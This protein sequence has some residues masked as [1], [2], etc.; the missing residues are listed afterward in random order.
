M[1]YALAPSLYS[2][3]ETL[4]DV[5][6]LSK[7]ALAPLGSHVEQIDMQ[8]QC[9]SIACFQQWNSSLEIYTTLCAPL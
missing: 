8:E 9:M 1:A 6:C 4:L 5:G 2:Q 7:Q 3:R